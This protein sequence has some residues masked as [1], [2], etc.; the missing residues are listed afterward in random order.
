MYLHVLSDLTAQ[1]GVHWDN[2]SL[3]VCDVIYRPLS[4]RSDVEINSNPIKRGTLPSVLKTNSSLRLCIIILQSYNPTYESH[5]EIGGIVLAGGLAS[6]NLAVSAIRFDKHACRRFKAEDG[7]GDGEVS[8]DHGR[9]YAAMIRWRWFVSIATCNFGDKRLYW[10]GNHDKW[11]PRSSS[12][13]SLF[14][15]F[16]LF[17]FSSWR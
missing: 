15:S 4:F 1:L 5:R 6:E 2:C 11:N 14:F 8:G 10:R 12:L 16:F 17:C 3:D 9:R 13:L 7:E